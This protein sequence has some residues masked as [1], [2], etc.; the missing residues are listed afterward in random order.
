LEFATIGG[1]V[2]IWNSH[3]AI[4][5]NTIGG[6]LLCHQGASLGHYDGDDLVPNNIRGSNTC[7]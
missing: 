2:D 1:S 4:T 6:S 5:G 3:P 7:V